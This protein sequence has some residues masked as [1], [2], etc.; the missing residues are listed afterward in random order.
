MFNTGNC[1][2]P[3]LCMDP[4]KNWIRAKSNMYPD[5]KALNSIKLNIYRSS[6]FFFNYN[7][8]L[9]RHLKI[10]INIHLYPFVNTMK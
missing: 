9:D 2:Q 10:L 5:T 6:I 3:I 1:I 4:K 8:K 7:F